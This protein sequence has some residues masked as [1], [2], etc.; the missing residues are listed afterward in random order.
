MNLFDLYEISRQPHGAKS[1][2]DRARK[3]IGAMK[4]PLKPKNTATQAKA[5]VRG[6][7]AA[8]HSR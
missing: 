5:L 3:Y 6:I 1:L 7:V 2:F 8:K 4:S